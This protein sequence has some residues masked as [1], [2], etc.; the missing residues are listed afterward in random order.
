MYVSIYS[1]WILIN[2]IFPL[3]HFFLKENYVNENYVNSKVIILNITVDKYREK[4]NR[5]GTVHTV[6]LMNMKKCHFKPGFGSFLHLVLP[7]VS[8]KNRLQVLI[9][10]R[11]EDLNLNLKN[12]GTTYFSIFYISVIVRLAY[13]C[14]ITFYF[15]SIY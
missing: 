1:S 13:L 2:S 10:G 7:T 15:I 12:C 8:G 11:F 5:V 3:N 14:W 4:K 6:G 9:L